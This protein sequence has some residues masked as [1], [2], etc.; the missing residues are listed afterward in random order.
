MSAAPNRIVFIIITPIRFTQ[1]EACSKLAPSPWTPSIRL[2]RQ[3]AIDPFVYLRDV[4]SRISAHPD[5]GLEEL[6]PGQWKAPRTTA[7]S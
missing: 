2:P 6:L 4:F 5:S 7:T 3:C 1:E